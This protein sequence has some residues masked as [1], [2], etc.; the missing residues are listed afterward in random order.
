MA[1]KDNL[2]ND[3]LTVVQIGYR[4]TVPAAATSVSP[5]ARPP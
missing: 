1:Y 5:V 4:A 2:S 3:L